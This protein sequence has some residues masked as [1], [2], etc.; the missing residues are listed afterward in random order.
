MMGVLTTHRERVKLQADKARRCSLSHLAVCF[1][2]LEQGTG[3]GAVSR[4][5]EFDV[6]YRPAESR[7]SHLQRFVARSGLSCNVSC[8]KVRVDAGCGKWNVN[9]LLAVVKVLSS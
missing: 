5:G 6:E 1:G 8:L 4:L 7:E 9:R 3:G 2:P